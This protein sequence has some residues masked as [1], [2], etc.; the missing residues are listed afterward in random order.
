MPFASKK[1]LVDDLTLMPIGAKHT[2]SYLQRRKSSRAAWLLFL[3]LDKSFHIPAPKPGWSFPGTGEVRWKLEISSSSSSSSLFRQTSPSLL[4]VCSQ[5]DFLHQLTR[6]QLI[7]CFVSGMQPRFWSPVPQTPL[8]WAASSQKG[9]SLLPAPP[10]Q[11]TLLLL[12]CFCNLSPCKP[13]P[14]RSWN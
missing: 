3:Q 5:Q 9:S 2:Q 6:K 13:L 7:Y 4:P 14:N 11:D 1:C 10:L 8:S 12:F